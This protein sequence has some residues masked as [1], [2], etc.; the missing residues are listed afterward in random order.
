MILN[1][2]V[3]RPPVAPLFVPG[4]RPE[5]FSK[6]TAGDADAII[7]D[8]EDSVDHE[9][10]TTA[11]RNLAQHG[12][13]GKPVFVRINSRKS[14][15]WQADISSISNATISGVMTSKSETA[16]DI[17]A[18]HRALGRQLPAIALVETAIAFANLRSLCRAPGLLCAAFGSFDY[19]LGVG[20]NASSEALQYA[21]S[22]LVLEC[23]IATLSSPL[24]GVTPT[25][26]DQELLKANADRAR[27]LGFGG[28]LAI[29]PA[30]IPTILSA[31]L[32]SPG[33]IE[34]ASKIIETTKL[35]SSAVKLDGAMIDKPV[36]ERAE[37]ILRSQ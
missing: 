33:E 8:L 13:V 12:I 15:Y 37:R 1:N 30:Q 21:R 6:A 9:D 19:A 24:D 17:A 35:N 25:L 32:P 5:R 20:C 11:R 3:I 18:V 10:K 36:I 29:H 22:K 27:A 34:W 26:N 4:N 23:R 14:D 7:L 16:D 28:S 2:A 31:F